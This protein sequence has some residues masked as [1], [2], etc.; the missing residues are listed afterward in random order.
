VLATAGYS[1]IGWAEDPMAG[2]FIPLAILLGIGEVSV[3]VTGGALLGQ[4]AKASMRGAVVGVFNTMGGIGIIIASGLGG[5][6]YD[7]IGRAAPFTMMGILNGLL[8]LTAIAVRLRA[9]VP[10]THLKANPNHE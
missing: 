5:V 4:E 1:L 9:G 8:L 3:I 7:A 10:E 6:L 2:S